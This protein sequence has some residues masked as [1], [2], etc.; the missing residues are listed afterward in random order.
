VC[1]GERRIS[2]MARYSLEKT[3]S[4]STLKVLKER[5]R[6]RMDLGRGR[7]G[8][9]EDERERKRLSFSLS[10]SFGV[11]E[12]KT[13]PDITRIESAKSFLSHSTSSSLEFLFDGEREPSGRGDFLFLYANDD[14]E[15]EDDA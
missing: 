1:W 6:S 8:F 4:P 3:A 14:D 10:L 12:L 13:P 7:C 9:I 15:D 2:T 5:E 11:N